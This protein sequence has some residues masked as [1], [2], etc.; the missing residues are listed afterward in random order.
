MS[1]LHFEGLV[2]NPNDIENS[3]IGVNGS[4]S[5]FLGPFLTLTEDRDDIIYGT[6]IA[7]DKCEATF[8]LRRQGRVWLYNG[9][10]WRYIATHRTPEPTSDSVEAPDSKKTKL[11]SN[12]ALKPGIWRVRM[13]NTRGGPDSNFTF[14]IAASLSFMTEFK[15]SLFETNDDECDVPRAWFE[16]LRDAEFPNTST[17]LNAIPNPYGEDD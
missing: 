12:P 14:E 4:K 13:R 15:D 2:S 6:Y 11:D 9:V 16:R 3:G 7:E 17:V 10:A 1:Y 5:L 8:S